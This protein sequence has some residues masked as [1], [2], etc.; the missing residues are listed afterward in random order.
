MAGFA[1]LRGWLPVVARGQTHLLRRSCR[2]ALIP[3]RS[4]FDNAEKD[5]SRQGVAKAIDKLRSH[6]IFLKWNILECFPPIPQR[7]TNI[8]C[9]AWEKVKNHKRLMKLRFFL[10]ESRLGMSRASLFAETE[11]QN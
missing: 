8:P 10:S 6:L 4:D 1:L 5:D 2:Q 11:L 9:Y 7:S 3:L